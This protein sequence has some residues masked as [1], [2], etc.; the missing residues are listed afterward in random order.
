VFEVDAAVETGGDASVDGFTE[1][2][3]DGLFDLGIN[4]FVKIFIWASNALFVV[5]TWLF[6]YIKLI[7][8]FSC[9][10][11]TNL[12]GFTFIK[13]PVII[14]GSVSTVSLSLLSEV[15]LS[16]VARLIDFVLLVSDGTS[17]VP[18][19]SLVNSVVGV[20][21]NVRSVGGIENVGSLDNL[22][23]DDLFTSS[24]DVLVGDGVT[25]CTLTSILNVD[26]VVAVLE[27]IFI[28]AFPVVTGVVAPSC[29][30]TSCNAA[31]LSSNSS[32]WTSGEEVGLGT[33]TLGKAVG[34]SWVGSSWRALGNNSSSAD[35]GNTENEEWKAYLFHFFWVI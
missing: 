23:W 31:T 10:S 1:D 13:V 20:G 21:F 4:S 35:W 32:S 27:V 26:V 15:V 3:T 5:V 17:N 14:S 30:D 19:L 11:C 16:L 9:T 8:N 22:S 7:V 33:G 18:V 12:S 28:L 34:G 6:T 25:W 2:V 29:W 24:N